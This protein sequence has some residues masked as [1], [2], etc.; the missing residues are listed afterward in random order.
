MALL[1]IIFAAIL[2]QFRAIFN[3]WDSKQ[4]SAEILQNARILVD[5]FNLNLGKAVRITSVST[6]DDTQGYINFED[7]Q[8]NA[9]QYG[10]SSGN[11]YVQ[12]GEVGNLS[13]LAGPVSMLRFTCYDAC[14]LA[15]PI[16]DA[17]IIR[18]V[19]MDVE[20][21]NTSALGQ[22]KTFGAQTYIRTNYQED[23]AG[24]GLGMASPSMLEYDALNGENPALAQIDSAHYLCAYTGD[25]SDGWACV[26][27]INPGTW[28]VTKK[29]QVEFD[30]Q[31]CLKPALVKIDDGHYLCV[32]GGNSNLGSAVILTVG[33]APGY[34][35]SAGA[36]SNYDAVQGL[37]PAV[38]K[39]EDNHYLCAYRGPDDDGWAVVLNVASGSYTIS[40]NTAFE[41]DTNNGLEPVLVQVDASNYLCAYRGP[42]D[43]GWS[44]VLRV[45]PAGWGISKVA[46]F[47]FDTQECAQPD[48][49]EVQSGY[50]LC[51]YTGPGTDGWAV[52]LAV[53]PSSYAIGKGTPFEFDS[54][55]GETPALNR[56][57]DSSYIC[58][59][60]TNGNKGQAV[61][62][63][64]EQGSWNIT[65]EE[66]YEYE[67][68]QHRQAALARIDG[69]HCLVVYC[70]AQT[71]GFACVL[72]TATSI[73]P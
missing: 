49:V 14:D 27:E 13:D 37:E 53:N 40:A 4:A 47:E 5:H 55:N 70:G 48:L 10:Y 63:L 45:N 19:K 28:S 1:G 64:V 8:G 26:L 18:S 72:R 71:D 56:I 44:A 30:I 60:T 22:S 11:G 61:I 46:S 68:G 15:A 43:D 54:Q 34:V 36:I 17:T 20:F 21:P 31:D 3:S 42:N 6:A 29:S 58:A 33:S 24:W 9:L 2:P 50:Y 38:V 7:A 25:G 66:P 59:Y 23:D 69:G 35:V 41:F 62:L 32:Y 39:M 57:D 67:R 16:T 51:A 52:I 73:R 65:A 12:F